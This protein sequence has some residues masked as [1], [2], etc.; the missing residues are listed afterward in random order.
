MKK[1]SSVIDIIN[2]D[3]SLVVTTFPEPLPPRMAASFA[4]GMTMLILA[5]S[6]LLAS[7]DVRENP[8][9]SMTRFDQ[10]QRQVLNPN[11]DRHTCRSIMAR[12]VHPDPRLIFQGRA[13]LRA[14]TSG[15]PL[16][17]RL[18]AT[19]AADKQAREREEHI[20]KGRLS[21]AGQ[22]I[23]LWEE[24]QDQPGE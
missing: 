10:R 5:N 19:I 2:I 1:K 8:A 4:G 11:S 6:T 7:S 20:L 22:G 21:G 16:T 13:L 24:I 15:P 14:M 12:D 3:I 18:L 23:P 17:H 9:R